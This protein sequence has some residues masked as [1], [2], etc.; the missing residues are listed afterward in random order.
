M[1]NDA[2]KESARR[3]APF[4][5]AA[6]VALAFL[7]LVVFCPS[8]EY[9]LM[10]VSKNF[11]VAQ[12][13]Y[14]P[15]GQVAIRV[16]AERVRECDRLSS[17]W[18]REDERGRIVLEP[19][20]EPPDSTLLLPNRPLGENV[21]PWNMLPGPGTYYLRVRYQCHP[22]WVTPLTMG[23]FYVGPAATE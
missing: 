16:S 11:E 19:L 12:V 10:P 8:V 21:G 1:V 23:P 6:L 3:Q 7:G 14:Q 15:S 9:A 17:S 22:L 5:K 18:Y 20:V 13:E 4:W 2:V